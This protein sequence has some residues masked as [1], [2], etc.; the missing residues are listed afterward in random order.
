MRIHLLV[1][2]HH[3][4]NNT[5]SSNSLPFVFSVITTVT[6]VSSSPVAALVKALGLALLDHSSP[7]SP[8]LPAMSFLRLQHARLDLCSHPKSSR[9]WVANLSNGSVLSGKTQSR[10][11][12]VTSGE[13]THLIIL[14][15]RN[16]YRLH[17]WTD[18]VC[19]RVPS[20]VTDWSRLLCWLF[21]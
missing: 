16:A 3:P 18:A 2:L 19:Q 6:F 9:K 11:P 4:I 7:S 8:A 21:Y 12:S 10:I 20:A 15:F 17:E 1:Q 14:H 5:V 13:S